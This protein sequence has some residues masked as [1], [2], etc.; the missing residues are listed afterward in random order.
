MRL[1]N[2]VCVI[3]VCTYIY[4]SSAHAAIIDGWG[5]SGTELYQL[6]F[7][8]NAVNANT[9]VRS[10]VHSFDEAIGSMALSPDG[11]SLFAV[12]TA[13]SDVYKFD[14]NNNTSVNIGRVPNGGYDLYGASTRGNEILMIDNG[15]LPKVW[16]LDMN[17]ASLSTEAFRTSETT[18]IGGRASSM[19][20]LNDDTM[21]FFNDGHNGSSF[22]RRAWTMDNDGSTT[23][24]GLVVDSLGNEVQGFNA[25]EMAADGLVYALDGRNIWQINHQGAAGGFVEATLVDEFMADG[26]THAWTSVVFAPTVVPVPAAIWLFGSGFIGLVGIARRK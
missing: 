1:K 12:S 4:G 8:S 16:S 19:V 21:L 25:T 2:I 6:S 7:D 11:N 24:L 14:L 5:V 17:N 18:S 20:S 26:A 23:L 10:Y 13:N 9:A 3:S 15:V 22:A